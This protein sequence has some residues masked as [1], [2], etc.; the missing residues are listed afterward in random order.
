MLLEQK[1]VLG[2]VE[3]EEEA[4]DRKDGTEIT[5]WKKQHGNAWPT[6][7]LAMELTLPQQYGVQK[8]AKA[9]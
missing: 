6:I 3:G 7:L 5:A 2:I 4:P 1:H 9:L 8:D